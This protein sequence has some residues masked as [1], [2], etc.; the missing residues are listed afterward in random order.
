MRRFILGSGLAG[1]ALIGACAVQDMPEPVE[2]NIVYDQN[3]AVC[4]GVDGQG[5]GLL[6]RNVTPAPPDLTLIAAGADGVFP[7]TAVLT[8]IDGYTRM[9][10]V[11]GMPEFGALLQGDTVPV[12]L[13]DGSLSPVPRQLAAL[14]TYLESIQR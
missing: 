4:H 2:G 1:L 8:K 3:C 11:A 9:E 6:A 7:R 12:Q 10:A 14:L 13:E 5:D